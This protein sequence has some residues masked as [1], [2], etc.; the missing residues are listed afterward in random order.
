MARANINFEQLNIFLKSIEYFLNITKKTTQCFSEIS[1]VI[2]Y[3]HQ[4]KNILHE[5]LLLCDETISKLEDAETQIIKATE[6]LDK[7]IH[8]L[9]LE[10]EKLN[11]KLDFL[12][13]CLESI[14]PTIEIN[15][16]EISNPQ[17]VMIV[18]EINKIEKQLELLEAKISKAYYLLSI[19]SSLLEK[20]S[21][22]KTSILNTKNESQ[23]VY[24]SIERNERALEKIYNSINENTNSC[25]K[26]S[27][28]AILTLKKAKNCLQR[29]VDTKLQIY[30]PIM[31][32]IDFRKNKINISEDYFKNSGKDFYISEITGLDCDNAIKGSHI[33]LAQ[34]GIDVEDLIMAETDEEKMKVISRTIS[35]AKNIKQ[36][37]SIANLNFLPDE[38]GGFQPFYENSN[39]TAGDSAEWFKMFENLAYDYESKKEVHFD[40]TKYQGKK[41]DF[42]GYDECITTKFRATDIVK[43]TNDGKEIHQELKVGLWG[44]NLRRKIRQEIYADKVRLDELINSEQEYRIYRNARNGKCLFDDKEQTKYLFKIKELYPERVRIYYEDKELSIE[45]IKKML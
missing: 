11:E 30:S 36:Y 32:H 5:V 15:Q 21:N 37:L 18:N 4:E 41:M 10:I 20:I 14:E 38:N 33:Y 13:T 43:K 7:L 25:I 31:K 29:Y 9:T 16:S 1:Q 23:S 45:E 42:L 26:N 27:E 6:I 44:S 19:C 3:I 2:N 39:Q 35:D 24:D 22:K 8:Q 28:N 40:L 17:Y 12:E 34:Q